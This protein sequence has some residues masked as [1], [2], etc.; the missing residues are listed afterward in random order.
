M[1]GRVF[2][3][4]IDLGTNTAR[5]LIGRVFDGNIDRTHISRR[6]TRLGGGFTAERGISE[7]AAERSIAALTE[8]SEELAKYPDVKLRGV[9]TSAVRD[10]VNG[11][12]FCTRVQDATGIGLE[13]I[14]GDLEGA[15]TLNGVLSGLDT[16]PEVSLLFDIGGG[17]TEY[18]VAVGREIIFSRSLPLGVVRLTEGSRSVQEMEIKVDRLLAGLKSDMVETGVI[19][20]LGAAT[21]IGTAGTATT[22]AAISIALADYDYTKVNNLVISRDEIARIQS[23]LLPLSPA[24]RLEQIIGMEKGREDLIV[25]GAMITMK[26]VETFSFDAMKVSDFGLLEGVLLS[27]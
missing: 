3:A 2:K 21:L 14:G 17:S 19:K 24:E 23:R 8:F 4:A 16:V 22:L 20:L 10:A 18:T 11:R 7:E 13:I 25:A 5:L 1:E 12:E 9:A 15:L 26:T 27:V 6:I